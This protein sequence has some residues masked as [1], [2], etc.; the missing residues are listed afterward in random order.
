MVVETIEWSNA[1]GRGYP[2]ADPAADGISYETRGWDS[3][4]VSGDHDPSART[5]FFV[6][7]KCARTR[8]VPGFGLSFPA[9][10]ISNAKPSRT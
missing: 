8:A 7:E 1:L 4:F 10:G 2:A 6:Q 5:E 9:L 3:R